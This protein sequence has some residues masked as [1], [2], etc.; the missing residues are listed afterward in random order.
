MT[1]SKQREDEKQ[2]LEKL[3]DTSIKIRKDA[4]AIRNAID[5]KWR[6]SY[7]QLTQAGLN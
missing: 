4:S 6:S 5:L 2:I 7:Q 1:K 3:K